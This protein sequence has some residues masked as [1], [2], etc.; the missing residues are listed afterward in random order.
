MS[1]PALSSD[2]S[3]KLLEI[4]RRANAHYSRIA[5]TTRVSIHPTHHARKRAAAL[6][7]TVSIQ[8]ALKLD[9]KQISTIPLPVIDRVISPTDLSKAVVGRER[10]LARTSHP[11]LKCTPSPSSASV[12][13]CVPLRPQKTHQD[14]CLTSRWSISPIEADSDVAQELP[15]GIAVTCNPNYDKDMLLCSPTEGGESLRFTVKL[16]SQLDLSPPRDSNNYLEIP[17][18]DFTRPLRSVSDI[19]NLESLGSG[20]A[21]TTS[22]CGP[23]TPVRL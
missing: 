21:S 10:V 22:S 5:A 16:P 12:Y 20:S 15:E 8:K 13:S 23:A 6:K 2:H 3:S 19:S 17:P 7:L 14:Q 9:P 18:L 4:V 1:S 11:L